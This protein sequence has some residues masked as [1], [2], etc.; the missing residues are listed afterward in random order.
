[1][2]TGFHPTGIEEVETK[3]MRELKARRAEHYLKGPIRIADVHAAAKMGGSCLAL[4]L[5]IHHRWTV[6]KLDAVT[7]PSSFLANFAIDRNAKARALKRLEAAGFITVKRIPGHSAL[8][9]LTMRTRKRR[10]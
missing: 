5:A 4:L 2:L 3:V 10:V 1:M 8:V 9:Q 6:T 7:L